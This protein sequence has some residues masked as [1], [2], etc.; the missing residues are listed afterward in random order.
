MNAGS[1]RLMSS[2]Q[3]WCPGKPRI[4]LKDCSTVPGGPGE[5]GY[6]GCPMIRTSPFPVSGQVA[7]AS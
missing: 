5:F 2:G 4:A 7:K 6:F 1:A 3:K